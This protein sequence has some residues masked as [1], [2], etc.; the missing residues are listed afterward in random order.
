MPIWILILKHTYSSITVKSI[1]QSGPI[2]AQLISD[3]ISGALSH[4]SQSAHTSRLFSYHFLQLDRSFV[5]VWKSLCNFVQ[6]DVLDILL[7]IS[8]NKMWTNHRL[9]C[10]QYQF[11][12]EETLKKRH[13]CDCVLMSKRRNLGWLTETSIMPVY[14][15]YIAKKRE[16][17]ISCFSSSSL[18]EN[19]SPMFHI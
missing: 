6:S 8:V 4:I 17:A 12:G 13:F 15:Y 18:Y 5:W 19:Y 11:C 3:S 2:S 1:F 14:T 10:C 9:F 7:Y 16:L